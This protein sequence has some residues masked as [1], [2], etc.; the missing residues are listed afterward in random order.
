MFM[1]QTNELTEESTA[2]NGDKQ[3]A[4]PTRISE[5]VIPGEDQVVV[6]YTR[7]IPDPETF[8][9]LIGVGKK[10]DLPPY[11]QAV[12]IRIDGRTEIVFGDARN[13]Y[14][15]VRA[16]EHEKGRTRFAW[17]QVQIDV[18]RESVKLKKIGL[19]GSFGKAEE[20]LRLLLG[21]INPQLFV[22]QE[23]PIGIWTTL[24]S[25]IYNPLNRELKEKAVGIVEG[26]TVLRP[27]GSVKPL[28]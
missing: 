13:H 19:Q 17:G 10:T 18:D 22:P 28:Y 8:H 21:R 4:R 25:Y 11:L 1:I 23:I 5:Y 15:I 24:A 7:S 2:A 12:F 20:N 3:A 6:R 14:E 9:D 26:K 27:L 16:I